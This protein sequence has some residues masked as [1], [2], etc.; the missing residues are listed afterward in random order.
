MR[1][2]GPWQPAH[3]SIRPRT[4]PVSLHC[5]HRLS[6]R[7]PPPPPS[8]PPCLFSSA[9][10]RV[11]VCPPVLASL[12]LA[13]PSSSFAAPHTTQRCGRSPRGVAEKLASFALGAAVIFGAAVISA[14][15]VHRHSEI[16]PKFRRNSSFSSPS[17]GPPC[18]FAPSLAALGLPPLASRSLARFPARAGVCIQACVSVH[19]IVCVFRCVCVCLSVCICLSVCGFVSVRA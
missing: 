7:S 1:R 18:S 2:C 15:H 11:P 12:P 5:S 3:P 17:C 8:D 6:S 19:K 13:R 16:S 4:V 9:H 14:A 10:A